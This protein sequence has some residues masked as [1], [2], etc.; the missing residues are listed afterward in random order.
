MIDRWPVHPLFTKTVA[1][2]ITSELK[3]FPK[4]KQKEVMILF[5]AHSLPLKVNIIVHI[6]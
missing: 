4:D 3:L 6:I 5:S 1:D 2:R